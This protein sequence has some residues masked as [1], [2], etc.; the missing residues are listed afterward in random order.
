MINFYTVEQWFCIRSSVGSPTPPPIFECEFQAIAATSSLWKFKVRPKS[1]LFQMIDFS[2]LLLLFQ[3]FLFFRYTPYDSKESFFFFFWLGT[4][5]NNRCGTFSIS[6]Y[7]LI[8]SDDNDYDD[9][10]GGLCVSIF[11]FDSLLWGSDCV[12]ISSILDWHPN[13]S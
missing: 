4:K 6:N 8:I 13:N 7:W 12:I 1:F 3:V 10:L 5:S 9:S 11:G 2:E